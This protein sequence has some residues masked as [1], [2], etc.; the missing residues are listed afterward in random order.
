MTLRVQSKYARAV[1][2]PRVVP[3]DHHYQDKLE[4]GGM[5]PRVTC[6]SSSHRHRSC[7]GFFSFR[8]HLVCALRR[9]RIQRN[10]SIIRPGY[11]ESIS[12]LLEKTLQTPDSVTAL[13]ISMGYTFT[14]ISLRDWEPR[15]TSHCPG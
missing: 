4:A 11:A 1:P 10:G 8:V 15:G 5:V 6:T 12:L 7:I 3:G 13:S 14:L 2:E 9:A